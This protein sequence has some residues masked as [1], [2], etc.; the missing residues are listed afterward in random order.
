M[1][2][3]LSAQTPVVAQSC[4]I[5]EELMK[6]VL[7][8][9]LDLVL[10]PDT[11]EDANQVPSPAPKIVGPGTK[12]TGSRHRDNHASILSRPSH[13]SQSP[14]SLAADLSAPQ[15]TQSANAHQTSITPTNAILYQPDSLTRSQNGN[16]IYPT[17]FTDHSISTQS[18]EEI[19]AHIIDTFD[20]EPNHGFNTAYGALEKG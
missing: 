13:S 6:V 1:F 3:K 11:S 5:L 12:G 7:T 15:H 20:A 18:P 4:T 16:E 2:K 19:S 10:R 14:S 8:R 17:S 9:E